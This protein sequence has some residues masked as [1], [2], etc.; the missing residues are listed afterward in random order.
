[1]N[2]AMVLALAG[3]VYLPRWRQPAVRLAP[4]LLGAL[5]SWPVNLV[6]LVQVAAPTLLHL[7]FHHCPYDLLPAVPESVVA[8]A[9][10]V[11]GSFAVG[12]ACLAAWLGQ[13]PETKS[14][15]GQEVGKLLRLALWGYSASVAMLS[16]ELFLA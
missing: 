16:F 7:A 1:V 11:V 12:W 4:L 6:F 8:I 14:F 9:L 10:F 15:L 3:Y 2:L 13:C 5:V